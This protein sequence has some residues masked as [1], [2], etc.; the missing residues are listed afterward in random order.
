[1]MERRLNVKIGVLKSD[2]GGEYS[3]DEFIELL[4]KEGILTE[5]GPA[6][7]PTANRVAECLNQTLLGR[8]RTQLIQS[9]L[10]LS[11]WGELAK[12]SCIQINSSPHKALNTET[13]RSMIESLTKGHVHPFNPAPLRTFGSLCYATDKNRKSK[14]GPLARR[15]IFVGLEEGAHAVCLWDK[16]TR[17]IFVT[18]NVIHQEDT[19]PALDKDHAP[20]FDN[21]T[22][23]QDSDFLSALSAHPPPL[24]SPIST[25]ELSTPQIT[26]SP[27][28]DESVLPDL[29]WPSSSSA[30]PI[31][32]PE[33]TPD[34][35]F[36]AP[37]EPA[38]ESVVQPVVRQSTNNTVIPDRYGF[39]ATTGVDS[40]H[41]T[42]SQAM[43]GPDRLAWQKAMEEE[44]ASLLQHDVGNLVDP[45]AGANILGGMWVF[46]RNR[47]AFNRIVRYKARWVV[48][49][50]HQIGGLDFDDTYAS[51][52]KVD[53]LRILLAL[54][55]ALG[56]KIIQF[57]DVTALLNGDMGDTVYCRQVQGFIHPTFKHRVWLLNKS[58]YGTRQA[59]RHWQQHFGNTTLKFNL[60]ACSSDS[61]VYVMKDQRGLI[62]I[63]LHVD[64][65]LVFSNPDQLLKEFETFLDSQYDVKWTR[66]PTLYLGIK[67]DVAEDFSSI[68][69]SQPQYIKMVLE[70]FCMVNCK[71]ARSPLPAKTALVAGTP[72]EIDEAKDIPY[73]QLVGCLQWIASSTRPDIVY[74]VT[75]LS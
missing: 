5:R 37:S 34:S 13:P 33:T 2:R 70:C 63:H 24:S 26:V 65:G 3:S 45:P 52:V 42:Y 53:S 36:D 38:P 23:H 51:V 25:E 10:P 66:K 72:D 29:N 55:V 16:Y 61:A 62:I 27:L 48:F 18:G 44:V 49:G 22:F 58:L 64:D 31:V 15:F 60:H 50:N 12:Y 32:C 73:Q 30:D 11:L 14:F 8:L 1:M 7:R 9:G 40:D 6:N 56:L 68:K 17:R 71:A 20:N 75:Q 43:A 69:I 59:A 39:S 28:P 35:S 47:D 19:F 41:P 74:A 67:L 54:A 4:K 21:S 46:N 57:D